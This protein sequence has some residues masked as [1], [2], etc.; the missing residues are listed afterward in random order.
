M[1]GSLRVGVMDVFWPGDVLQLV[2]SLDR[3]GY[4]RFWATEHHGPAQSAS[5]TLLAALAAASTRRLRIGT[6]G[7]LLQVRQPLLVAE[8]FRLLE[9]LFPGRIDLGIV[10][11]LPPPG[12]AALLVDPV[13]EPGRFEAKARQLS[14]MVRPGTGVPSSIEIGPSVSTIPEFWICGSG[15]RSAGLAAEL[16]CSFCLHA[17]ES[18]AAGPEHA[19][20]MAA[21][22]R[23]SFRPNRYQADPVLAVALFGVCASTDAL[24][25][26]RWSDF[27]HRHGASSGL[28]WSWASPR[29]SF[30]GAGERC[31]DSILSHRDRLG[32]RDVVVQILSED[33]AV[34]EEGYS[35][36]ARA[37]DL[38]RSTG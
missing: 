14:G 25:E 22:Y 10:G 13:P 15:P 36:L 6:A 3:L 38:E 7:V 8:E 28:G 16:G 35:E 27:L 24:A 5:P 12:A 1:T 37:L 19:E 20:R 11:A 30:L 26:R 2:G 29:P 17:F 4:H 32:C 18:Q 9:L 34:Q 33:R 31:R 23:G 21:E